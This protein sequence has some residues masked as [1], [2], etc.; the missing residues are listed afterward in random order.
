MSRRLS[1]KR[2]A[3]PKYKKFHVLLT[4]LLLDEFGPIGRYTLSE[5]LGLSEAST[6]SILKRLNEAGISHSPGQSS[7]RQGNWLSTKGIELVKK[8]KSHVQLVRVRICNIFP[9]FEWGI[10]IRHA[11]KLVK[12]GIRQRDEAVR[13]GATGAVTLIYR[14]S[15]WI[16]PETGAEVTVLG[17]DDPH[18]EDVLIIAFD[19][20]NHSLFYGSMAAAY[21]LIHRPTLVF[22]EG[23]L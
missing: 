9:E 8:L 7:G 13:A 21:N 23:Q 1:K 10:L 22:I 3:K 15:S 4:L 5:Y 20:N 14:D 19:E 16:F 12:D 17:F 18:E 11:G 2:G 6:R